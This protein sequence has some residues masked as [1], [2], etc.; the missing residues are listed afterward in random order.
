[1]AQL[2]LAATLALSRHSQLA[3][4]GDAQNGRIETVLPILPPLIVSR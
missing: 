3:A 1:M 4:K 2:V